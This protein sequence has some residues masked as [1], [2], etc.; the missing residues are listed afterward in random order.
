MLTRNFPRRARLLA[1]SRPDSFPG[2]V[3]LL[4]RSYNAANGIFSFPGNIAHTVGAHTHTY[5]HARC[6]P[7][8]PSPRV[9]VPL[10]C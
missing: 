2:N 4:L 10:C 7:C 5:V 8:E 3:T 6:R 9:L 1:L